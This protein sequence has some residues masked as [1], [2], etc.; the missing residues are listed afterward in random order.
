[1]VL[2]GES[3]E[4]VI[5]E[6]GV[7][8][9]KR[10]VCVPRV[11]DL[12]HTIL[13]KAHSSRSRMKCDIVDFVA[14]CPNCQQVKYEHQRPGRTLQTMPIP[15]W[16]WE[17]IAMDFVVSLPNTLGMFDSIWRSYPNSI[18]RKLF[19]Y[20]EFHFPSYQIETDGQ[21]ERT[22]QALE[23]ML[24]ACVI[25]FGGHWDKFLPLAECSSNNGYH[26]SINMA[27]LK[28]LYGR[29]CRSPIGWFDAFEVRPWV[30]DLLRDSLEKVKFIQ[31]KL[32]AAQSRQKEYADRKAVRSAPGIS[33]VNAE[34]YHGDGNYII[35]WDSV[36]LEENLFYEEEHVAILDREVSKLRSKEI[37]SIKVQWKNRP[38][39]ESTWESEA[40]MRKRY[41]HIFTNSGSK[42]LEDPQEFVDEVLKILV[43]MGAT[44]TEK[45]ELAS[46]NSRMF[47]RLGARC[48]KIAKFWTGFGHLGAI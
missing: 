33:C 14:Q 12:I 4:A 28:A 5:D 9:I 26:S 27:P 30:T 47:H 11:D 24:R 16:K 41:P 44:D 36:L 23:D 34:K 39:E 29:R 31:E 15:E 35:R 45:A 42:T 8:R 37:A 25:E 21:S 43:A 18:A 22:I 46:I 32:L 10:R 20:M 38:V 40:D 2:R 3:K 1:M 19:A 13:T 7:L 17:R 6:E 48:G